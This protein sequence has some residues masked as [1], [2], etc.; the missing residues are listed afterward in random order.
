MLQ[1]M[2]IHLERYQALNWVNPLSFC[3]DSD[4][5]FRQTYYNVLAI[6][7]WDHTRLLLTNEDWG[8][9][10]YS[11]QGCGVNLKI[12]LKISPHMEP[13]SYIFAPPPQ[14]LCPALKRCTEILPNF[15]ALKFYIIF[16]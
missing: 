12:A 3:L 6:H 16:K 11:C 15:L 7:F 2:V 1:S 9:S 4:C 14:I 10:H 5:V 13:A 8:K